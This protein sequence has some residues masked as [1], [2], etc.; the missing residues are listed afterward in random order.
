[1]DLSLKLLKYITYIS[2][3]EKSSILLKGG[4]DQ[5]LF[6][7]NAIRNFPSKLIGIIMIIQSPLKI[8]SSGTFL[9]LNFDSFD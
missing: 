8:E 3:R 2:D 5:N 6:F 7:F 4:S 9:E 1:M